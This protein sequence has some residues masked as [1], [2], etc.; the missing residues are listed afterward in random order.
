MQHCS[1]QPYHF[2]TLLAFTSH[3]SVSAA[4]SFMGFDLRQGDIAATALATRDLASLTKFLLMK[5]TITLAHFLQAAVPPA[6][7]P[8]ELTNLFFVVHH[9]VN[10]NTS[11][12]TVGTIHKPELAVVSHVLLNRAGGH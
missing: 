9:V 11:P 5:H 1:R 2:N 3:H 7:N 4:V 10:A 12:T 6:T 8:A